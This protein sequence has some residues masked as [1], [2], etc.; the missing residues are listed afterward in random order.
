[1]NGDVNGTKKTPSD[2]E[3]ERMVEERKD[4]VRLRPEEIPVK[5][6]EHEMPPRQDLRR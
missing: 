2:L 1:M 3:A 6:K 5:K 4:Q